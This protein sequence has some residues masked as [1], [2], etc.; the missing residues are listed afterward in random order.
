LPVAAAAAEAGGACVGSSVLLSIWRQENKPN[1][2]RPAPPH[3]T[4]VLSEQ[5][6]VTAGARHAAQAQPALLTVLHFAARHP[7]VR[8][9]RIPVHPHFPTALLPPSLLLLAGCLRKQA[10]NWREATAAKAHG[11]SQRKEGRRKERRRG[12]AESGQGKRNTQGR[13]AGVCG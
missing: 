2:V 12:A 8:L 10:K 5:E 7:P 4:N 1:Y 3:P 11:A 9:V 13:S 6:L